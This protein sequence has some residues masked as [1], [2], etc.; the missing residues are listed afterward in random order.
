MTE[1]YLEVGS[2]R[3]FAGVIEWPGWCRSGRDAD[4]A[5]GT[6]FAYAER[7]RRAIASARL[8]FAAPGDVGELRV[9]ERVDGNATTDFGA[10]GVQP[11]ADR[12]AVDDADLR[13]AER[14]LRACWRTFDRTVE[15]SGGAELTKGPRGGG[16]NVEGIV[17]HLADSDRGYLNALGAGITVSQEG[18]DALLPVRAAIVEGLW[19]VPRDEPD[20]VGPRGGRRWTP[21]YAVRRI[22]WHALDHAWE[23]EDRSPER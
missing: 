17:A 11:A 21:R 18:V 2:K 9:V 19:A 12:A 3:V 6:L 8:G 13:R 23:I 14:L 5:L 20:R 10:P 7:Y 15:A 22:A 4:A 16:R 1:T